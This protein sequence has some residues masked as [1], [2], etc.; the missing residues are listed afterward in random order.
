MTTRIK[1]IKLIK[2]EPIPKQFHPNTLKLRLT[3]EAMEV[4]DSF[5]TSN[6]GFRDISS[7]RISIINLAKRMG[8]KVSTRMKNG[9]LHVWRK[10]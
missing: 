2:G 8:I 1:I 10:S 7:K 4:G 6:Q 5:K 9:L 3:L